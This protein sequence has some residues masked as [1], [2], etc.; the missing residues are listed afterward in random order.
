MGSLFKASGLSPKTELILLEC[1]FGPFEKPDKPQTLIPPEHLKIKAK[2]GPLIMGNH[3][4]NTSG[5]KGVV[6]RKKLKLWQAQI[7][8]DGKNHAL[9]LYDTPEEG[10]RAYLEGLKIKHKTQLKKIE[11]EDGHPKSREINK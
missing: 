10:S 11:I 8:Y 3:K 6:Y 7:Y 4:H 9:G 1:V 2:G 5:Y